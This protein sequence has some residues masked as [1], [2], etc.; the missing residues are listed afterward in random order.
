MC[1][2]LALIPC[3]DFLNTHA[4][5]SDRHGLAIRTV[6]SE[7]FENN[8]LI[9]FAFNMTAAKRNKINANSKFI[10]Y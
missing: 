9:N 7:K 4:Q 8:Y 3:S 2:S 1:D 6:I 5:E 10:S